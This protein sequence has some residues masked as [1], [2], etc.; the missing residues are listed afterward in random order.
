VGGGATATGPTGR[1]EG[2]I[3][4]RGGELEIEVS[5]R[6]LQCGYHL[7]TVPCTALCPLYGLCPLS[8]PLSPLR[9]T[10][11]FT[12]L[13]PLYSPL[14]SCGLCSLFDLLSP[15]QSLSHLQ[16]SVSFVASPLWSSVSCTGLCTLSWPLFPLQTYI[17]HLALCFHYKRLPPL[18]PL[19]PLYDPMSPL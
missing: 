4:P 15:L 3:L 5:L 17:P 9:P 1:L 6:L 12:A 16:P 2:W 11:P 13:C 14:F 18:R 8:G 19:Y 7:H 10:V